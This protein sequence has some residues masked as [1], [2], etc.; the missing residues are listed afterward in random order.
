MEAARDMKESTVTIIFAIIALEFSLAVIGSIYFHEK[1]ISHILG[2][3][4]QEKPRQYY[5][6]HWTESTAIGGGAILWNE[7]L[8]QSLVSNA[9]PW[10]I[11]KEQADKLIK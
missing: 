11:S 1:T 2:H 8:D 4:A 3:P 5:I 9:G 7:Y 6:Q 10:L